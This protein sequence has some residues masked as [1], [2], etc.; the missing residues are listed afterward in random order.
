MEALIMIGVKHHTYI[1]MFS[2]KTG[3]TASQVLKMKI[4][5]Y[6]LSIGEV[7][8]ANCTG[9]HAILVDEHF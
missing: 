5:K 9:V 2:G 8:Q 4:W 1:L 6:P 7:F 3:G